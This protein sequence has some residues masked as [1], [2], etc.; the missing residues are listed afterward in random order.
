MGRV[1]G[2]GHGRGDGYS[3]FSDHGKIVS[4]ELA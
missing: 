4:R 1:A 2:D 3:G